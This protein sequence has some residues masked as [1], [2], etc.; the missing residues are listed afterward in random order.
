MLAD[1]RFALRA[2]RRAP[3]FVFAAV[4]CLGLGLGA[5]TTVYSLVNSLVVR[6]LPYGDSERLIAI[7]HENPAQGQTH[8]DISLPAVLDVAERSRTIA[9]VAAAS[10]R[11]V[12][13]TGVDRPEALPAATVSGRYFEL[14]QVRPLV[15]RAFRAEESEA[16]G[17]RVVV[18]GEQLWRERFGADPAVVGRPI[19]LDGAPYTIVGVVPDAAGISGD[20]ERLWI[21]LAHDRDPAQRGWH[22][23]D[24]IARLKPGTSLAAARD[25]LRAIGA[26]L[27]AEHPDSDR[28]WSIDAVPLREYLVPGEIATVFAVMMGAV[29]FVLL[30]A[31]ANVANLLLARTTGRTRELAVRAALGA[32]RG[33]VLR[34]VM[35]ESLLVALGGG[36]LGVGIAWAGVRALRDAVPVNYPAWLVFDV[37]WRVLGYAL[38]LSTV[39]GLL[40]GLVPA[41]R[42][43]RRAVASTLRAGGRGSSGGTGASRLRDGLVV[44]ELALS[45]VLLAGAGLMVKSMLRLQSTDPG[46]EPAGVLAARVRLGGER[47]D[48]VPARTALLARAV[49][50]LGALPGVV[51]VSAT[52]SAPLSGSNSSS[53]FDVDGRDV[54]EGQAPAAETRAVLPG[55]FA[56][57]RMPLLAGRDFTE[58]EARDTAARV[59]VVN[60]TMARRWWPGQDPLG[61]RVSIGGRGDDAPWLTV[62]GVTRDVRQRRLGR[63]ADEQL[64]LPLAA[65]ARREVTLVVRAA[66]DAAAL[67]PALRREVGALDA[68]LPFVDLDTMTA[69]VH[70]S[71][72][73]QRLYG[74]LFGAFAGAAVLLAVVGVYGVI[75]YAVAQRV[76]ELGVRVALGARPRDVASLMLRD[77][78]RLAAI[79]LAAGLALALATTSV[80]GAA[81]QGVSPRDPG[82]FVGVTAVLGAAALAASWI[83]ARRA[84]R[85]DPITALRAE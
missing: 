37:D 18:L 11:L 32:G 85:V 69:V 65:Q 23:Y 72:W 63:A 24:A 16:G 25:E 47:Y 9:G 84:A 41:L 36:V 4:L 50:R 39:T 56:T 20:R 68:A 51:S 10:T 43:T 17:A 48:A 21:P 34:L 55:Y 29:G 82:V 49:E 5:N 71:L 2:L 74:V 38:A 35:L 81:L 31:A 26:Q 52:S 53:R 76:R 60:E 28:G 33:R 3:G 13:L 57:M 58:A 30:I 70:R 83:P 66:G 75:A 12:N 61:R 7:T 79:G 14:L 19:A 1:L 27:A 59:V 44:A 62:V 77:G 54:P 8:V 22:A 15:G 73:L 80:L 78:A 42:A 45:L 64:Y 67:A 40:F 6:P 46:F